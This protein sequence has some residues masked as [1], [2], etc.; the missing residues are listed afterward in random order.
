MGWGGGGWGWGWFGGKKKSKEVKL[1]SK[2]ERYYNEELKKWVLPGQEEEVRKEQSAPPPSDALL[3]GTGGVPTPAATPGQQQ[4]LQQQQQHSFAPPGGAAPAPMA[5]PG[6]TPMAAAA[7]APMGAAAPPPMNFSRAAAK[8]RRRYVDTLNT[9][10][11]P[12]SAVSMPNLPPVATPMGSFGGASAAGPKKFQMFVPTPTPTS[13]PAAAHQQPA[14]IPSAAQMPQPAA[15]EA[16]SPPA[17]S[18]SPPTSSVSTPALAMSAPATP[19]VAEA[20]AATPSPAQPST[21]AAIRHSVSSPA[22]HQ[23]HSEQQTVPG[24]E[25]STEP[26][27]RRS[28]SV[29]EPIMEEEFL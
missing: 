17:A 26:E 14:D 6:V 29:E 7:P 2:L 19:P 5:A 25:P 20:P 16:L 28:A 15:G 12:T 21:D 18:V 10:T 8:G 3:R 11:A 4:Q 9:G 22:L 13:T 27:H 24:V 1:G 23:D